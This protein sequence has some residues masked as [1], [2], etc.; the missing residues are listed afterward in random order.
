MQRDL[1]SKGGVVLKRG[2]TLRLRYGMFLSTR[3]GVSR[4]EA[5]AKGEVCAK[6][7]NLLLF[8][9]FTYASSE[10]SPKKAGNGP[11]LIFEVAETSTSVVGGARICLFS[12]SKTAT[13]RF[14][15]GIPSIACTTSHL[16]VPITTKA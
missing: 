9:T 5:V 12:K 7:V 15:R 16:A 3:G 4:G 11:S 1:Q 14:E 2:G 8:L 6:L 10:R 13:K